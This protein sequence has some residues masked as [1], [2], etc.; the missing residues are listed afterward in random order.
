RIFGCWS[1]THR[2]EILF[3]RRKRWVKRRRV[4]VV[5]GMDRRRNNNAGVEIDRVFGFVGEIVEPSFI[6]VILESGS[7]LLIQS[8]FESFL[9][10][11]PR[12]R[13]MR[14]SIVGVSTPLSSAIRVSI[15][16]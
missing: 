5:G 9:P 2:G 14:S 8:S 11:R 10:L 3:R 12:S 7:V 13:R 16:R 15:S 4:A 6:L 1:R